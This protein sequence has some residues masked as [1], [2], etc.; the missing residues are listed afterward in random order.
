M[1]DGLNEL[2]PLWGIPHEELMAKLLRIFHALA[3][4][5]STIKILQGA[6]LRWWMQSDQNIKEAHFAVLWRGLFQI[7]HMMDSKL[8]FNVHSVFQTAIFLQL[9]Y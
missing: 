8:K 2:Q 5:I 4:N 1:K 6:E 7:C 9:H 3:K